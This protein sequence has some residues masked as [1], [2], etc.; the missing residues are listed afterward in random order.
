VNHPLP[1]N[2][3][4]YT[5]RLR[6]IMRTASELD[7]FQHIVSA[8]EEEGWEIDM[9]FEVNLR[10][11]LP[12]EKA[13]FQQKQLNVAPVSHELTP[14]DEKFLKELDQSFQSYKPK[15]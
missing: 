12:A 8:I 14:D 15:P 2:I 11:M 5:D 3:Q 9:F 4:R 10:P 13:L 6:E 7:A 1:P